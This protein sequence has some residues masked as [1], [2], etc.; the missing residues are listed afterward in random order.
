MQMRPPIDDMP[1]PDPIEDDLVAFRF[2]DKKLLAIDSELYRSKWFD[3]RMMTPL[4][5]TRHYIEAF[6]EVYRQYFATEFSKKA[7]A[8]IKVPS[9]DEIF[10]GLAV[11]N[12]K[13]MVQ[14]SGMWRGRQV[15][16]AI[17]MPYKEYIHTVMGLRLRFW[18][19]NHLPQAQH[20]Y[21]AEDVEKTVEKWE[22]MQ[23]AR[24][25]LSDNPA[26]MIENYDDIAHQND[27]HEWLF[28][29]ASLRGNP[30]YALAQF[31]NQNRLPLD[32]VEARFDPELVER[33]HRHIH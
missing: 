4:Q 5:A 18:G 29:Q 31:I 19:Q 12:E 3:Y 30:W 14:F 17:G 33:V 2:I 15:A 24:L 26:Y 16:D 11:L 7:S 13:H 32:K 20:L 1:R 27:Y 9:I 28:K 25:Y 10:S 23:A 8:F 6:G 22:E 21:K